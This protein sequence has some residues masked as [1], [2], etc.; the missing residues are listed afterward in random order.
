MVLSTKKEGDIWKIRE[1]LDERLDHRNEPFFCSHCKKQFQSHIGYINHMGK[2]HSQ[3]I[4]QGSS[5]VVLRLI[6]KKTINYV[7]LTKLKE[8][9]NEEADYYCPCQPWRKMHMG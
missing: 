5:H 8:C 1:I 7:Y 4:P 3:R 9:E 6:K 2:V